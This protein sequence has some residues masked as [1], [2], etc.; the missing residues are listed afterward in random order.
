M[1][2]F[3]ENLNLGNRV[4]PPCSVVPPQGHRQRRVP[5]VDQTVSRNSATIRCPA[6]GGE[7][8]FRNIRFKNVSVVE[9]FYII[10]DTMYFK[11]KKE[12]FLPRP[13]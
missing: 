9:Q 11:R 2:N 7:A 1:G 13:Q 10:F 5:E 6:E 3:A 12:K 4:R 8:F